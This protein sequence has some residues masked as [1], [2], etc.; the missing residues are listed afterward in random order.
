MN[1]N[2]DSYQWSY[3]S[4][5]GSTTNTCYRSENGSFIEEFLAEIQYSLGKHQKEWKKRWNKRAA[6]ILGQST[7]WFESTMRKH[8]ENHFFFR[9][10]IQGEGE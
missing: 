8:R 6:D 5:P 3:K 1:Q 2:D 7:I 10:D 4:A 9:P